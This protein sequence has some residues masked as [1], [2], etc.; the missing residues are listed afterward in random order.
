[1][2]ELV[3]ISVDRLEE[4]F[5]NMAEKISAKI[6]PDMNLTEEFLTFNEACAMLNISRPTLY[7]RM[8]EGIIPYSKIGKRLLFPRKL[9][10]NQLISNK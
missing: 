2:N 9:I 1:M 3:L 5:N 4:M 8:S 6:T 7:K 10:I